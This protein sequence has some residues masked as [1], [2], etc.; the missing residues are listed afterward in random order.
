MKITR[1]E[2]ESKAAKIFRKVNRLKTT[3]SKLEKLD[4]LLQTLRNM[5]DSNV[6]NQG[7]SGNARHAD[8]AFHGLVQAYSDLCVMHKLKFQMDALFEG[9]QADMKRLAQQPEQ[10][11]PSQFDSLVQR[12]Q[13]VMEIDSQHPEAGQLFKTLVEG[14]PEFAEHTLVGDLS[15]DLTPYQ[16]PELVIDITCRFA[17]LTQNSILQSRYPSYQRRFSGNDASLQEQNAH[18]MVR[19]R[20]SLNQLTEFDLFHEELHTKPGYA[21]AVNNHPME[22]SVFSDWFQ[23]YKRFL[24]AHNPQY[25]YGASPFTFNVFGCHK[26]YMPDVAKCLDQCWFSHGAMDEASR[27]FLVDVRTIA[28]HI[29]SYLPHCGFCPALTR[30]KLLIGVGVLPQY[31]NPECD[32]RWQYFSSGEGQ[33]GV[34]PRGDDIA[35]ALTPISL[36]SQIDASTLLEVGPTP[37]IEKILQF[38]QSRDT[39][40]LAE[41]AYRNLCHCLHCGAPYKPHTMTCSA[42]K[43]DFWKL[44]IKNPETTVDHLKYAK[45]PDLTFVEQEMAHPL[46]SAAPTPQQSHSGKDLSFDQLWSDPEVRK[47][48]STDQKP[49]EKSDTSQVTFD[50]DVPREPAEIEEPLSQSSSSAGRFELHEKLRSL[51][52]H[53]YRERKAIE[54]AF[55]QPAETS[56]SSSFAEESSGYQPARASIDRET[57]VVVPSTDQAPETIPSHQAELLDALKKLKPRKK[58]ELSKRG[59]VRVIYHATIDKELCPLCA[60]LDGMVM[61]PDDPAT[62]IFSPPL[63]PGCTC[64]REY[65]LKTEKPSKWPQVSFTFPSKELLGYLQKKF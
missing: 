56:P 20:F 6:N 50:Q 45:I 40:A 51:L 59:V 41:Q 63:F 58:S 7:T 17:D 9:I 22:E 15:F 25:C 11:T 62:D 10:L 8:P 65:V 34:L 33:S 18:A 19:L 52:S 26:L 27:L 23:C 13:V 32:R 36:S 48:L 46:T 2:L 53:K 64:R 1:K 44:A 39:S 3:S 55:S 16:L 24:N 21:I 42:C 4:E 12:L 30:E 47:I 28:A 38:L 43:I 49:S 31:V 60:Y 54:E 35:I 14:Y 57:S 37:Y 5:V 61:D 29:R